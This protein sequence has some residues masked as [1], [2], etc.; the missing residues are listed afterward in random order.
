MLSIILPTLNEEE[1]IVT[2]L[3]QINELDIDKEVLVVDGLSTDNTIENAR[4][5]GAKIVI[6]KRRGKGVAMATGVKSSQGEFIAF[7]DGDGTYPPRY[8]PAMQELAKNH[9][10][11]VASRLRN[12]EGALLTPPLFITFVPAYAQKNSTRQVRNH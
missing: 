10:V 12:R 2:T 7:L 4:K 9:D 8:L 11:V 5:L 3:S 6:E 1:G